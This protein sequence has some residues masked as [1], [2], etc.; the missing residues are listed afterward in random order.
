MGREFL[1]VY[2]KKLI[3][4][5]H[6]VVPTYQDDFHPGAWSD[7]A[8][9]RAAGR[10]HELGQLMVLI[11]DVIEHGLARGE[12]PV[13]PIAVPNKKGLYERCGPR[14]VGVFA[15]IG[16]SAPGRLPVFMLLAVDTTAAAARA[17]A[18][19]RV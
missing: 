5:E 17:L 2:G 8:R 15:I 16:A 1:D 12:F 6:D 14:M 4:G 18:A 10:T 11:D 13:H 3:L 9:H 19:A 7:I